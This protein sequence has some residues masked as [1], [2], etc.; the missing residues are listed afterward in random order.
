MH[1]LNESQ[2]GSLYAQAAISDALY[3]TVGKL[4]G[5]PVYD[6]LGGKARERIGLAAVLSVKD[7]TESVLDS[8]AE[9]FE[10][11]FRHLILKIGVEPEF[12]RKNAEALRAKYATG[13]VEIRVDANAALDYD[14]ALDLLRKLEPLDIESAEQPL[15]L[16]DLEG[17]AALARAVRIPLMADESVSTD[18]SLMDVI[19]H[20]AAAAAQTK[21]AKNGGIHHIRRLW[22]VLA[23]AELGINP[24]NHPATSVGTASVAHMCAA[25]PG[26]LMAG[27]FAVGVSGALAD[28]VV[29]NPI[30]PVDGE[31]QAPDGPGLGVTLDEE[32]LARLRVD[33]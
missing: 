33:L 5:V 10:K 24:G 8:A 31:V 3:D 14:G 11:G 29:E 13:T 16:D 25:W 28:D 18:R 6:L 23:A 15:A 12:D 27:P 1:A 4:L 2:P 17:M 26:P 22:Q 32:A 21:S 19:R 30:R 7:T 9:F 20:Q